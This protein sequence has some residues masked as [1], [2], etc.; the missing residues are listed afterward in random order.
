M[1]KTYADLTVA[2]AT[3]GNAILAS[4]F[5]TLFTNSNNFRK[6]PMCRV[7][8]STTLTPYTSGTAITWDAESFDTDS[9]HDPVTNT[10]RITAKTAGVYTFTGSIRVDTTGSFTHR[11]VFAKVNGTTFIWQS[12]APASGAN[13][14]AVVAFSYP[15][16]VNDYVEL[17]V[18]NS[19]TG[20]YSIANSVESNITATWLGQ[21]S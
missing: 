8:R 9:M 10:S 6:P 1:A 11:N 20:T 17:F 13:D 2:N 15:L 16:T 14:S 19:G 12:L 3:A 7:Y 21:V 5:S 18:S 4:D